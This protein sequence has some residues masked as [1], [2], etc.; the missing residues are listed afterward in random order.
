M[1][2]ADTSVWIDHFQSGNNQLQGLLSNGD[3]VCHDF[4]LGELACGNIKNR[5]EIL[6]LLSALP[7]VIQASHQEIL[8]FVENKNLMGKGLGYIDIHLLASAFL[9]NVPL[10]S[11][12]KGLKDITI[13]MKVGYKVQ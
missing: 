5:K 2:L 9:S 10:W 12:D 11:L 7:T 13:E 8:S 6:S 3:V 1:I 4:I